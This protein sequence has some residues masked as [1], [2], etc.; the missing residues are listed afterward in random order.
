M[1]E[2]IFERSRPGRRAFSLPACDVP[3]RTLDELVPAVLALAHRGDAVITLGAGSIGGVGRRLLAE[4]Q[5]TEGG[6]G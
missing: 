3:E 1:A 6:Q 2:T 4:L 5:R